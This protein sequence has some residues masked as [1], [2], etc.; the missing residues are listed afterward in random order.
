MTAPHGTMLPELCPVQ[1]M[2][3]RGARQSGRSASGHERLLGSAA[4]PSGRWIVYSIQVRNLGRGILRAFI[5]K[6]G[7]C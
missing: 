3:R 2:T 7:A 4:R 5:M 6:L 1:G